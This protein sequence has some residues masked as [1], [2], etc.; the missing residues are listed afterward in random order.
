[1]SLALSGQ[2]FTTLYT[3][4]GADYGASS[5]YS[6]VILGPQ[7]EIYGTTYFGGR[8]GLGTLYELLPPA[9]PGGGWTSVVLHSFNG[10]DGE[11]PLA[12]LA[13]GPN[14]SLYGV[15][16]DAVA[17]KLDPPTGTATDW[18][19]AV[20]Y[21]LA[22]DG[23]AYFGPLVFGL[24]LG[25]GQSLYGAS[26]G[27]NVENGAVYRLTP[28][29]A[30]GGAWTY[31]TLYTFPGGSPGSS[32]VGGLTAGTG[33]TLFGVTSYGGYRGL[34]TSF[35]TVFSLTPPAQAGGPWTEQVLHAFDP[36][37]GDGCNPVAGLTS[38]SGGVL[39][40]TTNAC[41]DGNG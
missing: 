22:E 34:N 23:E 19:Y 12:A 18:T 6:G 17:F 9:S 27:G 25:Y 13:M 26:P 7:G 36:G 41:G 30:A 21:K 24:P 28:P 29:P 4:N 20:L 32:A 31:T 37:I 16:S 15:T 38:E 2:T 11:D 39:Y 8:W 40:G 1:M 10:E 14:G 33:G 5:P 3:F 35:G